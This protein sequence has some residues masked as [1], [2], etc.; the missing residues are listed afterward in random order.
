M[1]L[2]NTVGVPED[3][4]DLGRG[5]AL[6]GQLEDLVLHLLAGHLHPLGDGAPV[7]QR[8]LG[9]TLARCVHSTHCSGLMFF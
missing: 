6:L 1:Y 7:R 2:C 4:T 9:D 3:D 5:Q 8:G